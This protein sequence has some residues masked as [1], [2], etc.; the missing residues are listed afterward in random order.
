MKIFKKSVAISFAM[1]AVALGLQALFVTHVFP[2]LWLCAILFAFCELFSIMTML[3]RPRNNRRLQLKA[4]MTGPPWS[5]DFAAWQQVE[6]AIPINDALEVAQV[7]MRSAGGRRIQLT[8][9]SVVT[10]WAGSRERGLATAQRLFQLSIVITGTPLGGTLFT[11]CARPCRTWDLSQT[12]QSAI[13]AEQL[14]KAVTLKSD[15]K[16]IRGS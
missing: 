2:P 12:P 3:S 16:S 10:G 9:P 11:C 5:G 15:D 1:T 6:I 8:E 13:Y 4:R 14:C 7:A